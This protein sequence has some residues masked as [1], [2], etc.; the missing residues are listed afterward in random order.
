MS[1]IRFVSVCSNCLPHVSLDRLVLRSVEQQACSWRMSPLPVRL[2]SSLY[3]AQVAVKSSQASDVESASND[4][5]GNFS[6]LFLST[7]KGT[8]PPL[9]ANFLCSARRPRSVL[10]C[11]D[12]SS[13]V[14]KL[15][16]SAPNTQG[17]LTGAM[18]LP[19]LYTS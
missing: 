8:L 3:C 4:G 2:Y 19:S 1:V 11:S 14:L 10:E 12:S 6:G 9:C 13:I 17:R 15:H 7:C 5:R 16:T 18:V